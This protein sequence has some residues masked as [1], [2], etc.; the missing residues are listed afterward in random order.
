MRGFLLGLLCVLIATAAAA[1]MLVA[2]Q[3]QGVIR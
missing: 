3:S 2:L 1:I